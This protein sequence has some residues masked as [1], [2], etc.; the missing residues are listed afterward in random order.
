MATRFADHIIGPDTHSNR[1]AAA[2]VP[3]GTIY[4]CTTHSKLEQ[5][6]GSAWSD[7]FAGGGSGSV[8]TDTIWDTKGDIVAASGADAAS[9]LAAG[10]NGDV[11]TVDSGQ[12]LGIKWAAPAGGGASMDVNALIQAEVF[13]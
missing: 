1:P 10:S 8:A 11:L 13:S 3:A 7:Y 2:A 5:S 4:A 9:K 6:S 12:T